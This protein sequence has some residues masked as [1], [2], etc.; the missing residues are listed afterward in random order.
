MNES[1]SASSSKKI[2]GISLLIGTAS[3]IGLLTPGVIGREGAEGGFAV[4]AFCLFILISAVVTAIVYF[5]LSAQEAKILRGVDLIARWKYS[6]EEREKFAELEYKIDRSYKKYLLYMI[7]FFAL[8]FGIGYWILDPESGISVFL[9]ML[10]LIVLMTAIFSISIFATHRKNS[11]KRGDVY[12]SR[13]GIIANRRLYSWKMLGTKLRQIRYDHESA[14]KY[15]EFEFSTLARYGTA[16][17]SVRIPVP[18]D[19]ESRVGNIIEE[20]SRC[21]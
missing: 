8:L 13:R 10:G 9:S 20:L 12:I 14:P 15:L 1:P 6:P 2:A 7:I 11:K 3:L 18:K 21:V 16:R 17:N 19:E 5:R 4:S